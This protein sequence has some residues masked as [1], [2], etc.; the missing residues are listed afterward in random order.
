MYT[1]IAHSF[2]DMSD[3]QEIALA[4]AASPEYMAKALAELFG[5]GPETDLDDKKTDTDQLL[6]VAYAF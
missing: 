3:I 1:P 4:A 5:V 2:T 6:S